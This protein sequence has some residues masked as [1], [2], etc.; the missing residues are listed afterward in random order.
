[1]GTGLDLRVPSAEHGTSC[2][3]TCLLLPSLHQFAVPVHGA[4]GHLEA[5]GCP[6][7]AGMPQS[8]A[9]TLPA[10]NPEP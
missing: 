5:R 4:G 2:Q 8:H 9:A 3:D 7:Q 1:M 6:P 10:A